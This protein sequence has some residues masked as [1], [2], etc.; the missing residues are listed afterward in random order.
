MEEKESSSLLLFYLRKRVKVFAGSVLKLSGAP[1]F[2]P[3]L[4]SSFPNFLPPRLHF[5]IERTDGIPGY[6]L[7]RAFLSNSLSERT[8]RKLFSSVFLYYSL[9]QKVETFIEIS[10]DKF[11]LVFSLSTDH[12]CPIIIGIVCYG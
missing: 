8:N 12:I 9:S 7:D 2:S 1:A 4:S 6:Y 11:S 5:I 10:R 3:F